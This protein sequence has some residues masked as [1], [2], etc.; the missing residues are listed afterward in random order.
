MKKLTNKALSAFNELGTKLNA[1]L[2]NHGP[3]LPEFDEELYENQEVYLF[4][5]KR[6]LEQLDTPSG[7]PNLG[8]AIFQSS[9]KEEWTRFSYIAIHNKT[10]KILDIYQVSMV[11]VKYWKEDKALE[12]YYAEV[13]QESFIT[14]SLGRSGSL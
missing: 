4:D 2:I 9:K 6:G 14:S 5:R 10:K 8:W 11:Q 3:Y 1:A 7:Y 13:D 12:V